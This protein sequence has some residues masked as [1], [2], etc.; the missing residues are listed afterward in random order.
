MVKSE[1]DPMTAPEVKLVAIGADYTQLR[2][3]M[4]KIEKFKIKLSPA[5]FPAGT[6]FRCDISHFTEEARNRVR[7]ATVVSYNGPGSAVVYFEPN[8]TADDELVNGINIEHVCEIIKRGD[9]EVIFLNHGKKGFATQRYIRDALDLKY[10]QKNESWEGIRRDFSLRNNYLFFDYQ[11]IVRVLIERYHADTCGDYF[12]IEAICKAIAYSSFVRKIKSS[13]ESGWH[14]VIC[15]NKKR[16]NK[17][18]K[19]N[20]NRFKRSLDSVRKEE[21]KYYDK[22]YNEDF[23]HDRDYTYGTDYVS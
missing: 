1:V 23:D 2:T 18:F 19:T 13:P 20:L 12:D 7:K 17:W 4:N 11:E 21:Q 15:A 10:G 16:M 3:I 14:Y 6:L 9:G 8:V 22:I 5:H